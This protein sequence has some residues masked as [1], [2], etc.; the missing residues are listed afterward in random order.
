MSNDGSDKNK[1]NKRRAERTAEESM[2][3]G[4]VLPATVVA[5]VS[6]ALSTIMRHKP[7]F[8]GAVLASA[9]VIIFFSVHLLVSAIA[10]NLDPI[11]TM[12]LAMFSYFA[13]VALIGAFLIVVTKV[14]SPASVSRPSFALSALAITGAWLAGEIRAFL[15][16]RLALPL[17]HGR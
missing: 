11:T 2:A 13:K 7:G 10:R 5:L 3:R 1:K 14:S 9:I 8:L 6:L 4:A 12:A 16:L 15:K 17:P